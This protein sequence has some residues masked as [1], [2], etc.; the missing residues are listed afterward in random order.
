[1]ETKPAATTTELIE[2]G[3]QRDAPGRRA[4]AAALHVETARS[5]RYF[6]PFSR[7]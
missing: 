4:A 3:E 6:I 2:T 7:G 1:M 5:R